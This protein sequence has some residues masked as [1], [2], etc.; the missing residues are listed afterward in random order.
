MAFGY[1]IKNDLGY[2]IVDDTSVCYY[3]NHWGQSSRFQAESGALMRG[4]RE[5]RLWAFDSSTG[6][7]TFYASLQTKPVQ[8]DSNSGITAPREP[9]YVSDDN[10]LAF[11]QIGSEGVCWVGQYVVPRPIISY[12]HISGSSY[13]RATVRA[14][15]IHYVAM[16]DRSTS[17]NFV[18]LSNNVP[19]GSTGD[20]YGVQIRNSSNNIVV[21]SRRPLM[22]IDHT[23]IVP[24]SLL[25]D[26]LTNGATRTITIPYAIPNAYVHAPMWKS[27]R[28]HNPVIN[29]SSNIDF[30]R[31]RQTNSTTFTV[32][33]V[34]YSAGLGGKLLL[35]NSGEPGKDPFWSGDY[36]FD[37]PLFISRGYPL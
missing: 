6:G 3:P 7:N 34:T 17:P 16:P 23:H 8:Y 37:C 1:A 35:T 18:L 14:N 24:A 12:R 5:D 32:D 21:D 11:W 31:I 4:W 27:F 20:N 30:A 26:V 29:A 25:D 10:S 19:S 22:S 9:S 28:R 33:R 36:F 2:S 13:Q 15:K